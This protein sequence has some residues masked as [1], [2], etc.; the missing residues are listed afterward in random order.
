MNLKPGVNLKGLQ[1]QMVLAAV[2]VNHVYETTYALEC[3]ITS[4]NDSTHSPHSLHYEGF[5]LDFRTHNIPRDKLDEV[6]TEIKASLGAA[7][8]V[9]LEGRDTPNEHIHVEYDPK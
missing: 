4:A 6:V 5:A 8:D 2:V 9:L 7:F 3:T 1:P